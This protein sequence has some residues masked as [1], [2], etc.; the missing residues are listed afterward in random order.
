MMDIC[1]MGIFIGIAYMLRMTWLTVDED[2]QYGILGQLYQRVGEC[3][4]CCTTLY[5]GVSLYSIPLSLCKFSLF[6]VIV[7]PPWCSTKQDLNRVE[8]RLSFRWYFVL[9]EGRVLGL[10]S[11]VKGE[12]QG[13]GSG[14][15]K[16]PRHWRGQIWHG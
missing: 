3:E 14:G 1:G 5:R 15:E 13:M 11:W 7:T 4:P 10:G 2:H 8:S 6:V 12:R 9:Q 16:S